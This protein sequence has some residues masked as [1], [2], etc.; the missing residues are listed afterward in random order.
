MKAQTTN[1]PRVCDLEETTNDGYEYF[2]PCN[3]FFSGV[4]F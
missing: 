3:V 2:L 1:I 4:I